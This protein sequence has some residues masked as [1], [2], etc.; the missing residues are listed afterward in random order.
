MFIKK[1]FIYK[2]IGSDLILWLTACAFAFIFFT[3][4]CIADDLWYMSKIHDFKMGSAPWPGFSPLWETISWHYSNDNARLSNILYVLL[5][6][7]PPVVISLISSLVCAWV[8]FALRK[9]CGRSIR[10]IMGAVVVAALFSIMLPWDDGVFIRNFQ[11]NYVWGL[12]LS[13]ACVQIFLS[14]ERKSFFLSVVL[15]FACGAWHEG[16][17]VPL[18]VGFIVM[19]GLRTKKYVSPWNIALVISMLVGVVWLVT[20]PAFYERATS[21]VGFFSM[22]SWTRA[23]RLNWSVALFIFLTIIRFVSCKKI[24]DN[25]ALFSIIATAS[26]TIYFSNELGPR[27]CF[28]ADYFS[29]AGI[30]M[31]LSPIVRRWRRC[32]RRCLAI[33]I[34]SLL[35]AHLGMACYET[36]LFRQQVNHLYNIYFSA[37]YSTPSFFGPIPRESMV[38]GLALSK[39]LALESPRAIFNGIREWEP[40][41][42]RPFAPVP[43]SLRF[44]S[45]ESSPSFPGHPGLRQMLPGIYVVSAD[46]V[47]FD[48]RIPV[49]IWGSVALG[50][51]VRPRQ[52]YFT[53][54][55]SP[56]D[57]KKY[58]WVEPLY[59]Y[60]FSRFLTIDSIDW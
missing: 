10:G 16:F 43:E 13:V 34:G 40:M 12:G 45:Y 19:A 2:N 53:P 42:C 20:A 8:L 5:M 59:T 35:F 38:S 55:V 14:P 33:I 46:S 30:C 56:I 41:E 6:S 1:P 48:A 60:P 11:L 36:L 25:L 29:I 57:E 9:F 47:D 39:P 22:S 37:S 27:V 17:S 32:L 4:P 21:F 3:M 52:L 26:L 50:P 7:L 15:G 24:G 51:S 49:T 54:F 18:I 44:T 28:V 31:I 58:F 23:L